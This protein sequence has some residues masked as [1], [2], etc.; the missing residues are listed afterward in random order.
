MA[1]RMIYGVPGS[2]KSFMATQQVVLPALR[3]NRKVITNLSLN[4]DYLSE[5]LEI[6]RDLIQIVESEKGDFSDTFLNV[7]DYQDDWRDDK[8]R[9][10]LIVVDEAHF[11]LNKQRKKSEVLDIENFFSTHRQAGY[12][13]Y[14]ITQD[15]NRIPRD[16]LGFVEIYY[17]VMK[18]KTMGNNVFTYYVRDSDRKMIG[19]KTK[20]YD[21]EIF[22]CYKSHLLSDGD[23]EEDLDA[24]GVKLVW[25]SWPFI[26]AAIVTFAMIIGFLFFDFSLN[27]FAFLNEDKKTELKTDV[28][29]D[30]IEF[31][32]LEN[33]SLKSLDS[34]PNKTMVLEPVEVIEPKKPEVVKYLKQDHPLDDKLVQITTWLGDTALVNIYDK[35][36]RDKISS[37]YHTDFEKMGY[38]VEVY[39]ECSMKLSYENINFFIDCSE[40]N[41]REESATDK[42]FTGVPTI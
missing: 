17:E 16:I 40:I 14:L 4:K 37:T 13:I 36:S 2:G 30:N 31:V 34:S 21:K 3:K 32:E 27:P 24:V 23:V 33:K 9:A 29:L 39:S 26:L 1:V 22:K 5:I 28:K 20:T 38:Q 15:Y 12:D 10:P 11:A 42:I 25:F 7:E 18:Q 41:K 6:D 35:E 19:N 8:G